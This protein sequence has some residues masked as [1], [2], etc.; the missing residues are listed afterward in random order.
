MRILVTGVRGFIGRHLVPV[1]AAAG[2]E[3]HGAVRSGQRAPEGA[4]SVE[5][6]LTT[7]GWAM[8]NVDAVVHLAQANVS[9]V[10]AAG[11]S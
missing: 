1:L 5:M 9:P 6:D 2:H 11:A 8:P 7:R 4:G 3:V 10:E